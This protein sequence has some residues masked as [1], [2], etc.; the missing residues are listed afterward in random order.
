MICLRFAKK[1]LKHP[2]VSKMFP[3][4]PNYDPR[5]RNSEKFQVKFANTNRLKNSAIPSLQ[6]M[7]NEDDLNN[8][9]KKWTTLFCLLKVYCIIFVNDELLST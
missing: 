2:K 1:S 5:L 8:R 3:R 6:R 9:I 7:L 4:N